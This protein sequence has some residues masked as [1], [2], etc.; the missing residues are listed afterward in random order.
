MNEYLKTCFLLA[1][2]NFAIVLLFL[3][4]LLLL[5]LLLRLL[6]TASTKPCWPAWFAGSCLEVDGLAV[7][8]TTFF[9]A[10]FSLANRCFPIFVAAAAEAAEVAEVERTDLL[11]PL[12]RE[13]AACE[14]TDIFGDLEGGVFTLELCSASCGCWSP[15]RSCAVRC[16]LLATRLDFKPKLAAFLSP[17]DTLE[18]DMFCS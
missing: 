7:S 1:L 15:A 11:P 4:L 16:E 10:T 17:V 5:L 8:S 9:G 6:L 2:M 12:S 14:W 13:V 18:I 3:L